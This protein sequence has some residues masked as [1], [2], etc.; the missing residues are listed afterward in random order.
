MINHIKLLC[1][2]QISILQ[3]SQH[4]I[5]NDIENLRINDGKLTSFFEF[6]SAPDLLAYLMIENLEKKNTASPNLCRIKGFDCIVLIIT[7]LVKQKKKMLSISLNLYIFFIISCLNYPSSDEL[8]IIGQVGYP[9]QNE[10][11]KVISYFTFPV[12]FSVYKVLRKIFCCF[13]GFM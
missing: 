3:Y 2:K 9:V 7:R 6:T 10:I 13:T 11:E 5:L 1:S 4:Y 8:D 12:Y